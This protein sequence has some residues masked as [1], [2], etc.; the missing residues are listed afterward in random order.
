MRQA[1]EA[2][3]AIDRKAL[4]DYGPGDAKL[5]GD[6]AGK[7]A[8]AARALAKNSDGSKLGD[9]EAPTDAA[10][11]PLPVEIIDFQC[12]CNRGIRDD[13]VELAAVEVPQPVDVVAGEVEP[14]GVEELEVGL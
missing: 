12:R 9:V 4:R 7:V 5:Y 11:D 3:S 2:I 6:A 13:V 1:L 10:G 8:N 14:A